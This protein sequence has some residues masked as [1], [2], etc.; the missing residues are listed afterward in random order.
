MA[1]HKRTPPDMVMQGSPQSQSHLLTNENKYYIME[2]NENIMIW[3]CLIMI[4]LINSIPI[5]KIGD[6]SCSA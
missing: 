1:N 5:T 4:K 2:L 3:S 6:L